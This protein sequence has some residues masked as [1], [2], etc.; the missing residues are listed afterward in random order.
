VSN[1]FL[2]GLSEASLDGYEGGKSSAGISNASECWAMN[3]IITAEIIRGRAM[4]RVKCK[5]QE[6]TFPFHGIKLS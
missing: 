3:V 5:I 4:A 1:L 6:V 2:V